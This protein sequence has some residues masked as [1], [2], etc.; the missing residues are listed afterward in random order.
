MVEGN[1]GVQTDWS[2][3]R[4]RLQASDPDSLTA[5]ELDRLSDAL[6]WTDDVHA[7]IEVRRA[8][9]RSHVAVEDHPGAALAAWRLFY[10][11]FLVGEMAV[12][13][14]WLERCRRHAGAVPGPPAGWLAVAEADV[15]LAGG[16][17]EGA[18]S[19]A[20]IA[21]EIGAAVDDPDLR[22]MA[23]QA[24]GRA[25]IA[26][27]NRQRGLGLLDQAMLAVINDELDPLYTGWVYC[28]VVATC[29]GLADLRRAS[30]WSDAAMR[31]CATL[32]DGSMYPGLCRV[33]AA[34]LKLLRGAWGTAEVDARRASADLD[35]FDPRYGGEASYVVGELCRLSGRWDEAE[36]AFARAHELG[37]DPQPG[38]GLLRCAQGRP[39]DA[40][41]SLRSAVRPGPSAPLPRAQLLAALAEVAVV[42]DAPDD[43]GLAATEAA[44]L[45]DDGRPVVE[46]YRAVIEGLALV[47][48]GE[49][50][51]AVARFR[52]ARD[53]FR[54]LGF[55]YETAKAQHHLG[56][57][58]QLIGDDEGS[59]L[60]LDAAAAT[61]DRLGAIVDR[62]NTRSARAATTD[63]RDLTSQVGPVALTGRELEVVRLV[64]TGR[65]NREIGAELSL[66]PHT[67]ARH[68]SNILTKLEVGSRAAATARAYEL[69]LLDRG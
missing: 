39:A 46:A 48:G 67:I 51:E 40:V 20:S 17:A 37:R 26:V 15:A 7:S 27:G 10:D 56:L 6:F 35:V 65:S 22:A 1:R 5:D 53:H 29:F 52:A 44:G 41:V 33:Y 43:A 28:N 69:G 47:A 19:T 32:A 21:T 14:G 3:V 13:S 34:E 8:A 60:A 18:R 4:R 68:L 30:E 50:A 25:E 24:A 38:L 63:E 57:A 64:A 36:A 58:S 23:L 55:P 61:F 31:W 42:A 59:R 62:D 11:H 66:S 54:G 9:Y 16:D 45:P 49:P 12:A 2:E